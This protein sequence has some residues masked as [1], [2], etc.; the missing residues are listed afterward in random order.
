MQTKD[1]VFR[2]FSESLNQR[3]PSCL[4]KVKSK[5]EFLEGHFRRR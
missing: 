1:Y 4:S 5:H 2:S 3:V